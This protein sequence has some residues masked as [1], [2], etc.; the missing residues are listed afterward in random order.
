MRTATLTV[1]RDGQ[2]IDCHVVRE[3]REVRRWTLPER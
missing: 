2:A 1:R 3:V